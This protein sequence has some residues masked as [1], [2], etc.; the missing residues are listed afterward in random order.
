MVI[1]YATSSMVAV[2]GCFAPAAVKSTTPAQT[3]QHKEFGILYSMY[4][5]PEVGPMAGLKNEAG[6]RHYCYIILY[7]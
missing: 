2:I 1:I 6:D 7:T 3:K 4:S 5:P